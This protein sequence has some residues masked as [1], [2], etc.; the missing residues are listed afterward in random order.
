[1]TSWTQLLRI[2]LLSA[3]ATRLALSDDIKSRSRSLTTAQ[4]YSYPCLNYVVMSDHPCHHITILAH[5]HDRLNRQIDNFTRR[6][7]VAHC[8][9][10]SI[11]MCCLQR[12]GDTLSLS[13]AQLLSVGLA[14]KVG[15]EERGIGYFGRVEFR[16]DVPAYRE[17][18][19][20][21]YDSAAKTMTSSWQVCLAVL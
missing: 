6:S 18:G 10:S 16:A 15:K 2:S 5:D 21:G 19:R 7:R 9:V 1:M 4:R 13:F 11:W 17:R 3:T 20:S 14:T 12:S 8:L